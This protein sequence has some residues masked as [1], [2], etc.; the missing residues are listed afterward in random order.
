MSE[1]TVDPELVPESTGDLTASESPDGQKGGERSAPDP[2]EAVI[3]SS[4][5]NERP[6]TSP[7]TTHKKHARVRTSHDSK[8]AQATHNTLI[9]VQVVPNTPPRIPTKLSGAGWDRTHNPP[10]T[11]GLSCCVS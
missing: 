5:T 1:I 6:E 11:F 8:F 7:H 9:T 2:Q 10:T 3:P 4:L